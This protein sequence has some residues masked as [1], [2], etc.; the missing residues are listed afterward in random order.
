MRP[1]TTPNPT[2]TSYSSKARLIQY[3]A[4]ARQYAEDVLDGTI[5]ACK[6]VR[7]ACK[8]H[9]DDLDKSKSPAY[10]YHFDADRA[11]RACLFIEQLP[12]PEGTWE[13][14]TIRLQP[15]QVFKTCCIFGWLKKSDNLRRFRTA[16]VSVPRKNAKSTWAAGVALYC[17]T[18][19]GEFGAQIYCA[20]TKLAQAMYVFAPAK[21][22]A[23]NAGFIRSKLGVEINA[24]SII[25]PK[26][27]SRFLPLCGKPGDGGG[28]HLFVLDEYHEHPDNSIREAIER[29]MGAR[30][31][32]LSLITTTAGSN[33]AG[34]CFQVEQYCQKILDKVFDRETTFCI[35]Y[36]LDAEDDWTTLESAQKA[37]PNWGLS[38]NPATYEQELEE[39]VQNATYQN[40]FK[41]KRLNV[42]T[43][44]A[45]GWLNMQDWESCRDPEMDQASFDGEPCVIGMDLAKTTDL[46]ALVKVFKRNI[47]GVDHFY[48]FGNRYYLPEARTIDPNATHYQRWVVNGNLTAT[49]GAE[50]DQARIERD[51][52][53]EDA[54]QYDIKQIALDPFNSQYLR[55][56][57][58]AETSSR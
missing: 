50:T 17:L 24:Q 23:D 54:I 36:G 3:A 51:I 27:N 41:T 39:A 4:T 26:T 53:D 48:T 30:K 29:G 56:R 15:W 52:V 22:M 20:A 12:Y 11:G 19:D 35:M 45:S 13:T 25:V 10:P 40:S 28:A 32:P 18:L 8:R 2:S 47:N 44:A 43:N 34:P 1:Q 31:Q 49:D 9:L 5:P 38:V 33:I 6:W 14:D 55:Q 7:L 16:Y 46:T 37:N 57:V 21:M 58:G 42:W